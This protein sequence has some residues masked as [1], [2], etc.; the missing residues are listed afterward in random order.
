MAGQLLERK[1]NNIEK[2]GAPIVATGNPGCLLQ[3]QNGA[4][5]RGL[6]LKVVHPISLLAEA[7]RREAQKPE[8]SQH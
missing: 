6:P 1:I 3:V 8:E 4:R 5:K 2:T 7:Y